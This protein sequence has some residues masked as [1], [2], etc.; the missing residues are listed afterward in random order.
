MARLMNNVFLS[1]L[2]VNTLCIAV[3]PVMNPR[4][5]P[6]GFSMRA[7]TI[8]F[9]HPQDLLANKYEATLAIDPDEIEIMVGPSHGTLIY[10]QGNSFR[11]KPNPGYTGDDLF[12][13]RINKQGM[14]AGKPTVVMITIVP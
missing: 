14:P 12:I 1:L 3:G 6:T 13:Y 4:Y 10:W 5:N 8:L 11:Y 9:F 7:N 2:F